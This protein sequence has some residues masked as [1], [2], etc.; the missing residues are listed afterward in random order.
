MGHKDEELGENTG[1]SHNE[2]LRVVHHKVTVKGSGGVTATVVVTVRRGMVWLSIQPPFTWEAI[3]EPR[4]VQELVRTL[5]VAEEEARK[6]VSG[7][8]GTAEGKQQ[9]RT[10]VAPENSP[11]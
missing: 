8:S 11:G 2:V 4:K 5:R 10:V 3:M 6:G 7:A 9:V 1:N